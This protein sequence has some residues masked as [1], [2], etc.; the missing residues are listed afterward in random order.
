M[1]HTYGYTRQHDTSSAGINV[2]A[3]PTTLQPQSIT[4]ET[5]AVCTLMER[6][7]KMLLFEE[8]KKRLRR[9][10]SGRPTDKRS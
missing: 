8:D 10:G 5:A 4:T 9:T 7:E 2:A 6:S 1:V 3:G